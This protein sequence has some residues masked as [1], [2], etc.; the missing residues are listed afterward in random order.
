MTVMP[1]K[2]HHPRLAWAC[3]VTSLLIALVVSVGLSAC[4]SSTT[5]TPAEAK[6]IKELSEAANQ[7]SQSAETTATTAAAPP[8]PPTRNFIESA[9][10][11]Q[12]DRVS[13]EGRVGPLLR[14]SDAGAPSQQSLGECPGLAGREMFIKLELAATIDSSLGATVELTVPRPGVIN[15]GSAIEFLNESGQRVECATIQNANTMRINLGS[16]QPHQQSQLK[17][18]WIVIV[19]AITPSEP[20]PT[21]SSLATRGLA[22]GG[23]TPIVNGNGA[24]TNYA[25][26]G[27]ASRVCGSLLE[28]KGY[29]AVVP[30]TCSQIEKTEHGEA[31]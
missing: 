30:I 21:P 5:T 10:T 17:P 28:K 4:G 16:L 18:M 8:P 2:P 20:S 22:L 6:Q 14:P 27:Q 24:I 15:F 13:V 11:N 9:S 25:V 1:R 3:S 12:G 23:M 7:P 31:G 26:K 29:L 19:D